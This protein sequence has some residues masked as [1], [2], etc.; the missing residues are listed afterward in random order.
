MGGVLNPL[1]PL[2]M[3]GIN[4]VSPQGFQDQA[5][6][7]TYDVV[8]TAL[9]SLKDQVVPIFT[10]AD[11]AWRG[12]V[13]SLNTGPF[14]IRFTDGQGYYLSSGLIHVNNLQGTPGDPWIQFPETLYPAG[15]RVGIDITDLSNATNTIQILLRG[16]NRYRLRS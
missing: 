8:L 13:V 15:G 3:N 6:D 10:E 12:L 16:V 7:Y 14:S 9:E 2:V 4:D 1:S 5:F 11:F